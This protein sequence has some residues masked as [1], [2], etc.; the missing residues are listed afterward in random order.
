MGSIGSSFLQGRK[1]GRL[2]GGKGEPIPKKP[3]GGMK[4]M[5]VGFRKTSSERVERME[6]N[7]LGGYL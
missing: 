3:L 7:F 5:T 4:L 2:E 6:R 1:G